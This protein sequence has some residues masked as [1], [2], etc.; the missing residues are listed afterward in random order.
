MAVLRG[1]IMAGCSLA[2]ACSLER[3]RPA[4]SFF[5]AIKGELPDRQPWPTKAGARRAII[6]SI[7]WY[8]GSRRHST[9]GYLSPAEFE[10]TGKIKMAA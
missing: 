9:L 8:N 10:E 3:Q 5:A 1:W 2:Q 4:E 6:E 7:A